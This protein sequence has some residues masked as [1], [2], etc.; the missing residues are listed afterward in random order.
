MT[1]KQKIS[2][3]VVLV[4]LICS[5]AAYLYVKNKVEDETEETE[6]TTV[7]TLTDFNSDDVT[8]L[9]YTYNGVEYVMEKVD[10]TWEYISEDS[11]DLDQSQVTTLISGI[12]N[13]TTEVKIENVTDFEQYGLKEPANT[14][15]ITIKDEILTLYI[16]DCNTSTGD[17]YFRIGDESTVY[18]V[19]SVT[20][21]K[22]NIPIS[23]M[24][25]EETDS[26]EEITEEITQE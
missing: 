10:E 5:I 15:T 16:G 23:T 14:V 1:K 6:E 8:A 25:L 26:T 9:S 13:I 22:F 18:T 17:Y 21:T 7:Y 20:G 19:D 2:L 24:A 3:G 4:L 12:S 11:F